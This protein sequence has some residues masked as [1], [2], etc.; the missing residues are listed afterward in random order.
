MATVVRRRV[1]QTSRLFGGEA[2]H[3]RSR[4]PEAT[5]GEAPALLTHDPFV[6]RRLVS[7]WGALSTWPSPTR[8]APHAAL[9]VPVEV[10]PVGAASS[11]YLHPSHETAHLPLGMFMEYLLSSTR[12][13]RDAIPTLYLAQHA[14]TDTVLGLAQ[15]APP[16]PL[17]QSCVL[18]AGHKLLTNVWFGPP[19]CASPPHRDPYHNL[20]SV[21]LG[22]K[23]VRLWPSTVDGERM[24]ASADPLHSNTSRVDNVRTPG[25]AFP[26]FAALPYLDVTL[27]PGDSLHIPRSWWHY[28]EG[29]GGGASMAVSMWWDP[30]TKR[31]GEGGSGGGAPPPHTGGRE[32]GAAPPPRPPAPV[33]RTKAHVKPVPR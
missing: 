28:V 17:L 14:L 6:V 18:D 23:Y 2:A 27:G 26:L 33:G 16:P 3:L 12:E 19:G 9:S 22:G 4:V 5:A 21:V 25:P 13:Q 10:T 29:E 32:G 1:G 8:W 15:E 11:S 24:Y 7:H 30:S 31:K 20:Y